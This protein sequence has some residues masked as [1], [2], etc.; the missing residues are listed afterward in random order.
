MKLHT[1]EFISSM[2]MLNSLGQKLR[3]TS[4]KKSE[5][6]DLLSAFLSCKKYNLAGFTRQISLL[7]VA[8]NSNLVPFG[9][10]YGIMSFRYV[11]NFTREG[12][13]EDFT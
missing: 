3:A 9:V 8:T 1:F 13:V 6:W 11:N 2:K 7:E 10:Y 4:T 12:G 5:K